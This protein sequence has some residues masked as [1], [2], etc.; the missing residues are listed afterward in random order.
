MPECPGQRKTLKS[1]LE[2]AGGDVM[3]QTGPSELCGKN[4]PP[5]DVI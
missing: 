4:K 2:C 1:V 3:A 5:A